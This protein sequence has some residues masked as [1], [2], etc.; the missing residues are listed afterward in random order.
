MRANRVMSCSGDPGLGAAV[1]CPA[2]LEISLPRIQAG[3]SSAAPEA[4][5]SQSRSTDALRRPHRAIAA[6]SNIPNQ[7]RA[8]QVPGAAR[9]EMEADL[10]VP[11]RRIRCPGARVER[12][13]KQMI[14]EVSMGTCSPDVP[15][16]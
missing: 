4:T 5:Q 9:V 16:E 13:E 15:F 3:M 8:S 2:G 6:A 1:E 12:Y 10:Q 11:R 14:P 7:P